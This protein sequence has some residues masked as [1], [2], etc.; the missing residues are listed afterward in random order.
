MVKATHSVGIGQ[1][2]SLAILH[3]FLLP[4]LKN[5]EII[6]LIYELKIIF[7]FITSEFCFL[8]GN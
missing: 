6:E 5:E 3:L 4:G 1:P 7:S 8:M 2:P